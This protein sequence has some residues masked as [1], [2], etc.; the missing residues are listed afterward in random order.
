MIP[1]I[2]NVL[3]STWVDGYKAG[4]SFLKMGHKYFHLDI[5]MVNYLLREESY[6]WYPY[7]IMLLWWYN[8]LISNNPEK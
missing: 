8:L 7:N 3:R 4:T 2:G 1:L 5:L 6:F